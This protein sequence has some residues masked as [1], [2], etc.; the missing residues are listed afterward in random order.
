MLTV[1][2]LVELL[3]S[4]QGELTVREFLDLSAQFRE[5]GE[6]YSRG[7]VARQLDKAIDRGILEKRFGI[8][9]TAIYF[10]PGEDIEPETNQVSSSDEIL[11][12]PKDNGKIP[13]EFYVE[14]FS[15]LN[16]KE[17][18]EKDSEVFEDLDTKYLEG[19][20]HMS[21]VDLT[22]ELNAIEVQKERLTLRAKVIL[23]QL[24]AKFQS[25]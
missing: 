5:D 6:K 2:N 1:D 16:G 10:L 14:T 24:N 19:L 15:K 23:A 12:A 8:G 11:L 3:K 9:N 18:L 4:S 7:S 13:R 17:I 21:V 22:D 20:D 25:P